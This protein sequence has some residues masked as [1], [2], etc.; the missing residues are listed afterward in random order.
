V[1]DFAAQTFTGDD[2]VERD[3]V[4][5][6][7]ALAELYQIVYTD[8][9]FLNDDALR[10]LREVVLDIGLRVMRLREAAYRAEKLFW[11][12]TPQMHRLQHLPLYASALNPRWV[13]CYLEESLVG[14]NTN[15]WQ[16][17]PAGAVP[18]HRPVGRSSSAHR[19]SATSAHALN[20]LLPTGLGAGAN[21]WSHGRRRVLGGPRGIGTPTP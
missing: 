12:I 14:T 18:E 17:K 4:A 20:E 11:R 1:R 8:D 7:A 5:I 9:M 2:P 19:G 15:I 13:Q 6:T 21:R 10:R 16:K 3:V